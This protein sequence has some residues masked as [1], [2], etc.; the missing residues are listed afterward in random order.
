MNI[1]LLSFATSNWVNAKQRILTQSNILQ[2]KFKLFSSITFLTEK[3]LDVEY[4]NIFGEYLNDPG[5]AY[6]SWKPYIIKNKLEQMDENDILLYMDAG[7]SLPDDVRMVNQF[8]RICENLN[9]YDLPIAIG[10]TQGITPIEIQ[11]KREVLEKFN[12]VDNYDFLNTYPHYEAGMQII[13]NNSTSNNFIIK[14]YDF[15]RENY[16]LSI[17]SNRYDKTNQSKNF[18]RNGGDQQVF[19]CLLFKEHKHFCDLWDFWYKYK[20]CTRISG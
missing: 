13:C 2:Q 10:Q 16:K 14:W 11:V 17:H 8:K 18:W 15:I 9:K 3:D 7:C 20:I 19:Q 12:L 5:F 6:W 1:H 4:Y